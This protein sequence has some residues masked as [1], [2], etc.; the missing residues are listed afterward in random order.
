MSMRNNE[1]YPDPT[2]AEALAKVA[3]WEK[4]QADRNRVPGTFPRYSQERKQLTGGHVLDNSFL[5]CPP[6]SGINRDCTRLISTK[7]EA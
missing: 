5:S 3:K 1:G 6:P 4:A 7:E 2:A